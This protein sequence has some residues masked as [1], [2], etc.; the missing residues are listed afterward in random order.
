MNETK[1]RSWRDSESIARF[2]PIFD[3]AE[4]PVLIH[5]ACSWTSSVYVHLHYL[6]TSKIAS[7]AAMFKSMI[8]H[9]YDPKTS[10]DFVLNVANEIGG[11]SLTNADIPKYEH[12]LGQDEWCGKY[13]FMHPVYKNVFIAG[14]IQSDHLGKV[15]DAGITD[16]INLRST[17]EEVTLL[18]VEDDTGDDRQTTENLEKNI[19]DDTKTSAYISAA[20]S[21]NYEAMNG[22]EWGDDESYNETLEME[23]FKASTVKYAHHDFG[24]ISAVK[25][26]HHNFGKIFAVKYANHDTHNE[27]GK[28]SSVKYAH[29][30][31]GKNS[32]VKYAHNEFGKNYTVKYAHNE[33]GKNYTVKYAHN[34]FGKNYTVNYAHN[35][36]GKNY[37][38]KYIH[39]D[40]VKTFSPMTSL[41]DLRNRSLT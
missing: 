24:K 10:D 5:C 38:V 41:L 33:F 14:Q 2:G 36:F 11:E 18:N 23:A 9:G 25:Y 26:A 35:E 37:T 13:G 21:I 39:H 17:G 16:V 34:E 4:R 19:I 7:V 3:N 12:S 29:N 30:E 27:F 6:N 1:E 8:D 28:N 32:T 40:F 31:F 22:L 20:A 15:K